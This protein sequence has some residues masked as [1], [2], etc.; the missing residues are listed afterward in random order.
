[1]SFKQSAQGFAR[2]SAALLLKPFC[3]SFFHPAHLLLKAATK[4]TAN[5]FRRG[6][7]L[8]A[9]MFI[10]QVYFSAYFRARRNLSL[11]LGERQALEWEYVKWVGCDKNL[12][13]ATFVGVTSSFRI[14]TDN[15]FVLI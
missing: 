12:L 7:V 5:S 14:D 2:P 6:G 9:Q 4:N 3:I 8:H 15:L 1:M 10:G 11:A 13:F